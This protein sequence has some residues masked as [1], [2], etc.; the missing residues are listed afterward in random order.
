MFST[1]AKIFFQSGL[2][3]P[4]PQ[5][6]DDSI[7]M[8]RLFA[9]SKESRIA[10]ATPSSTAWYRSALVEYIVIPMNVPRALASLCGERSPMRYG[11]K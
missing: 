8:P 11:R 9:T 1:L 5:I 3:A 2:F 6:L 4:P 10:N 7:P